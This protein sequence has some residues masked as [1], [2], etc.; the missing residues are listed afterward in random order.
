MSLSTPVLY[1]TQVSSEDTMS[2]V[3]SAPIPNTLMAM[4]LLRIFLMTQYSPNMRGTFQ[5]LRLRGNFLVDEEE[6]EAE[7]QK[8][9][10]RES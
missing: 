6:R 2:S 9:S 7:R 5:H 10:L 8:S 1:R 4:K 3:A